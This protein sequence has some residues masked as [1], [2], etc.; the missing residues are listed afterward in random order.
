MTDT[1]LLITK[2]SS[3]YK[4]IQSTVMNELVSSISPHLHVV[5]LLEETR[6]KHI[7][8]IMHKYSILT[9]PPGEPNQDVLTLR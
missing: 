7:Q 6:Q 5:R 8:R 4:F 1:S 9:T 2:V 3:L